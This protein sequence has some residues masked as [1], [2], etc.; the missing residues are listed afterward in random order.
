MVAVGLFGVVLGLLAVGREGA[1]EKGTTG[2]V[3]AVPAEMLV[4]CCVNQSRSFDLL[5]GTYLLI[6][7]C[8]N[9][10]SFAL[11][12]LMMLSDGLTYRGLLCMI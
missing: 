10:E 4:S 9:E 1:G 11:A 7:L 5:A 12:G 8:L 2:G 3:A 6:C